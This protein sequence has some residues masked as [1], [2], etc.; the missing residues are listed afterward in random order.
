MIE[1]RLDHKKFEYMK[2]SLSRKVILDKLGDD[3]ELLFALRDMCAWFPNFSYRDH[4]EL[5]VLEK[6][7]AILDLPYVDQWKLV[8]KY[9]ISKYK[10]H[11]W[12]PI[13]DEKFED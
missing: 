5:R 13:E 6:E 4:V 10:L 1:C 9:G 7:M 12:R 11:E 3:F 8:E 2:Q